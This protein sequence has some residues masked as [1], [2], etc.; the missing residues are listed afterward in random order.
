LQDHADCPRRF[1]LRYLDHMSWPAL[2]SEPADEFELRQTKGLAFHRLIQQHWL[3]LPAE[4]LAGLAAS[5]NL[6]QW[7]HNFVTT[8]FGIEDYAK[9]AELALSGS[10]GEHRLVAKYD[11]VAVEDGRVIVYDWKTYARRPRRDWLSSRWQTRIYPA[12]LERIPLAL[13]HNQPF[14]A[15]GISMVY[16][17][18]EYPDDPIKFEYDV[19]QAEQD[20]TAIEGK[21]LEISAASTFPMTEDRNMC[22]YCAFRSFCGRGDRAGQPLD[23]QMDQEEDPSLDLDDEQIPQTGS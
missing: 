7:W 17:F 21:I 12:L 10:V 6:D 15:G 3:G 5:A 18:A 9:V 20:W 8:A 23:A 22:R 14:A 1:Q 13:N 16:W 4:K 19:K 11:L 2:E